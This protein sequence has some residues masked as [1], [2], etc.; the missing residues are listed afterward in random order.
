MGFSMEHRQFECMKSTNQTYSLV[1]RLP[2]SGT[3]TLKLCRRGEPC[4]FRVPESLG[5]RL[6]GLDAWTVNEPGLDVSK[7]THCT[8]HNLTD[9]PEPG[10]EA[11]RTC[12]MQYTRPHRVQDSVSR[13]QLS[14]D[15]LP[16]DQLNLHKI[17]SREINLPQD[18]LFVVVVVEKPTWNTCITNQANPSPLIFNGI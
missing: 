9:F 12:F 5:T 7:V 8:G 11:S 6:P 14:Q 4:L 3:E 16:R 17:N 18:Q 10:N 1:P 2:R 15:Q 13:D